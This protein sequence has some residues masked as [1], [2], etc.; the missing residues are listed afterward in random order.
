MS[1]AHVAGNSQISRPRDN[2]EVITGRAGLLHAQ[3]AVETV[4][5]D[6][7]KSVKGG[8]KQKSG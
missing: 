3:V 2:V 7:F 8:I 4:I 1:S 5:T 6:Y